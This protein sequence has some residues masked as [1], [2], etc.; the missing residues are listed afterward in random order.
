MLKDGSFS[1]LGRGQS[2]ASR[3]GMAILQW[4]SLLIG[5]WRGQN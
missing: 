5:S 4:I 2:A 3:S 1:P